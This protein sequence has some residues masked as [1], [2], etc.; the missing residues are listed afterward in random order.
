MNPSSMKRMSMGDYGDDIGL[1]SRKDSASKLDMIGGAEM[2]ED[3]SG[4]LR[5]GKNTGGLGKA[6]FSDPFTV[7]SPGSK[8]M[9]GQHVVSGIPA[10]NS[11]KKKGTIP[12]MK[13]GSKKSSTYSGS[14]D[15]SKILSKLSNVNENERDKGGHSVAEEEMPNH[16]PDI[17]DMMLMG[18]DERGNQENDEEDMRAQQLMSKEEAENSMFKRLFQNK[19][20]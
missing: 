17:H 3:D 14:H 7:M 11:K 1:A 19:I 8:R 15:P 18:E 12:F 5:G 16:A 4:R 9:G 20:K 13:S 2:L 6:K 10:S